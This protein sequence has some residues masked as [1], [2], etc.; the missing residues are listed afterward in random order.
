MLL[1]PGPVP[2]SRRRVGL[3]LKLLHESNAEKRNAARKKN[4]SLCPG[5][6]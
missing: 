2:L 4:Q 6:E 1:G 5:G 3:Y